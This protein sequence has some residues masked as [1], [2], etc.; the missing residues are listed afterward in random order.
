MDGKP[1]AQEPV[2]QQ[3][4]PHQGPPLTFMI[5]TRM[6]ASIHFDGSMSYRFINTA[7]PARQAERHAH[8][9]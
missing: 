5:G 6:E 3:A 4:T 9:S 8:A 2:R 1:Y 7:P